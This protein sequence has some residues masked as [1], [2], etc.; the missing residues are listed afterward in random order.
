MI[1]LV[2]LFVL[3]VA[4]ILNSGDRSKHMIVGGNDNDDKVNVKYLTLE[5][6][7]EM[8]EQFM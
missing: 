5:E 3:I 2:L 7:I 1:L 4:M 8:Q 6:A